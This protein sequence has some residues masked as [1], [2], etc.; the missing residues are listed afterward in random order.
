MRT[1]RWLGPAISL[2]ESGKKR[3][4]GIPELAHPFGT[5]AAPPGRRTITNV[6]TPSVQVAR[7][8]RRLGGC[9][10]LFGVVHGGLRR[11]GERY[12]VERVPHHY[13]R[14]LGRRLK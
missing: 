1:D 10:W 4:G 6:A 9:R 3:L 12:A 8:T 2:S 11:D 7:W 5:G 13:C 14:S